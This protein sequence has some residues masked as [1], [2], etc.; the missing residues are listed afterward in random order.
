MGVSALEELM[1]V[2]ARELLPRSPLQSP[3]TASRNVCAVNNWA[4]EASDAATEDRRT[5]LME[6]SSGLIV[7]SRDRKITSK[8][9]CVRPLCVF[10]PR[11][12]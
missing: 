2:C 5:G 6:L 10:E 7:D 1:G 3:Y 8:L 11:I 12:V 4:S 9:I